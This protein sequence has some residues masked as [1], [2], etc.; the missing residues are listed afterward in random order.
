MNDAKTKKKEISKLF[1]KKKKL[2]LI[3]SA[4]Q[5]LKVNIWSEKIKFIFSLNP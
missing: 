4:Y 5:L 2:I 1:I 3:Y